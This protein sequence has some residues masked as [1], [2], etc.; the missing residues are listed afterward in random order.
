MEEDFRRRLHH[1]VCVKRFNY[2]PVIKTAQMDTHFM[3]EIFL[4]NKVR[5]NRMELQVNI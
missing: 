3:D 5:M 4:Y 2:N 1:N